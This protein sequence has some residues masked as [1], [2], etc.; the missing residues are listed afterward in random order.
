MS[1]Q[2]SRGSAGEINKNSKEYYLVEAYRSFDYE[3]RSRLEGYIQA[4]KDLQ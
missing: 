3:M 1:G 4:M 2:V